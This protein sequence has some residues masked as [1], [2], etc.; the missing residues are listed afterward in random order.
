MR[1]V[2]R[3]IVPVLILLLIIGGILLA[4]NWSALKR[5]RTAMSLFEKDKI[6]E[7]FLHIEDKFWTSEI[8]PGPQPTVLPKGKTLQLPQ[9]FTYKDSTINLYDYIDY[10][11][12][13]GF[14]VIQRD[15][16]VYEKYFNGMKENTSHI[17]WSVAKSFTSA[18]FGMLVD[19][20]KIDIS[21]NVEDYLPQFVGSAYEGVTVKNVLQMSSGVAFDEDYRD[22]NSDINKFGRHFALGRSLEKFCLE[23]RRDKEPGTFNHYV[24]LNTQVLSMIASKVSGESFTELMQKR[25]WDKMGMEHKAQWVVDETGTEMALGG[26]NASLRDYGKFGVL[27]LHEGNW[28]GEQL[29]SKE[30]VKAS[31]TPDAPHLMPGADNPNSNNPYGYGFQWWLPENPKNDFLACGIYSQFIYVNRDKDLVIVKLTANHRF[32]DEND[33]SKDIHFHLFQDL[34]ESL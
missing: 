8:K 6:V 1:K 33:N 5:L 19:E 21:K 15:S 30:W 20:G 22:F 17:S 16:I 7:N 9:S 18:I 25:I 32:K 4:N 31:L 10:T 12:T 23:M 27:F 14:L 2:L 3:I 13:N 24:S 29:V 28:K 11:N 26:F 34:A